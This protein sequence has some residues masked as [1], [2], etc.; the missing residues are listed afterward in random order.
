MNARFACGGGTCAVSFS[1][2]HV[3]PVVKGMMSSH[4]QYFL[5]KHHSSKTLSKSCVVFKSLLIDRSAGT[6]TTFEMFDAPEVCRCK[7]RG[8]LCSVVCCVL[9]SSRVI[10]NSFRNA[11]TSFLSQNLSNFEHCQVLRL[12]NDSLSA[13]FPTNCYILRAQERAANEEKK[14]FLKAKCSKS[15][16]FVRRMHIEYLIQSNR[17]VS[18]K[19]IP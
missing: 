13:H 5:L 14:A 1:R 19:M 4:S 6:T 8:G 2:T 16:Y 17:H 7:S 11:I 12:E 10:L 18:S 3:L 9:R 15:H